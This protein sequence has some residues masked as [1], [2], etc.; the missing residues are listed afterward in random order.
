[1]NAGA[2][3]GLNAG[4]LLGVSSV[5]F[6]DGSDDRHFS[7]QLDF[8]YRIRMPWGIRVTPKVL[9]LATHLRGMDVN[10][11][12]FAYSTLDVGVR[13]TYARGRVRPYVEPRRAL[14]RTAELPESR[15]DVLNYRGGGT[16]WAFGVEVPLAPSGRG[17]DLS[18]AIA[19][20]RF[21]EAER[22]AVQQPVSLRN[23]AVSVHVG[24]SGPFT[25]IS[26]PWQ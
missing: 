17:L 18:V 26:L 13:A 15:S 1:M 22:A 12:A 16:A 6:G 14:V 11:D 20:G 4:V 21:T 7:W 23:R 9:L 3:T 2:P 10:R 8:G 5:A 19:R 24:W 25:G